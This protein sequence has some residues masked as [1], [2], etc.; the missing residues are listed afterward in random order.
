MT[1][2]LDMSK[3][4]NNGLISKP[5]IPAL[6]LSPSIKRLKVLHIIPSISP[7]RGGPSKAVLEMVHAL[8]ANGVDAEI[9]TTNEDLKS[10][11]DVPLGQLINYQSVPIRFFERTTSKMH[12]IQEF[13]YSAT[14]KYWL[15]T[16]IDRYDAIHVHAIFSFLSSYSMWLARKQN[17]PFIVRPI[18]QLEDWALSQ[19]KRKKK[20]YLNLIEKANIE[21]A[22]AVHFTAESEMSQAVATFPLI[23]PVVIPLGINKI[24]PINIDQVPTPWNIKAKVPVICYLSRLHPK[25]GIEL[26][27]QALAKIS[28]TDFQLIIAGSGG[29]S[30][31]SKLQKMVVDLHLQD[32]CQFIGF[33]N[34]DLKHL[35]LQNSDIFALTSHSENFGISVLESMA[36]GTMPFISNKVALSDVVNDHNL[37]VTC[38]L[39]IND[40]KSKIEK[41]LQN[42][43]QCI[44]Y[45]NRSK[46]FVEQHYQWPKIAQQLET[47]YTELSSAS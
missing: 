27:L 25:K 40:I 11:L 32:K 34:G 38:R 43:D 31:E 44:E 37:G 5:T 29:A 7:N 46:M 28:D 15:K 42:L 3:K 2:S 30:Y 6:S 39:D 36:N 18:G 12:A 26:L 13:A 41:L 8:R 22:S 33:I 20:T 23:K 14:F 17:I 10:S 21:A 45:G 9:A 24:E 35:L 1:G 4:A 19:S 16:N 47:V